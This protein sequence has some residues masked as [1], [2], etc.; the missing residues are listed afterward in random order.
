MNDYKIV[1]VPCYNEEDR[2][3]QEI[4]IS[5]L[6]NFPDLKIIFVNDGSKDQTLQIKLGE[7]PN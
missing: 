2:L 1:V 3:Q 5:S 4:F 7:L 6:K